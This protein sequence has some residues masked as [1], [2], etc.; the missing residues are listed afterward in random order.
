MPTLVIHAP[1]DKVPEGAKSFEK[2]FKEGLG[3]GYAIA[4]RLVDQVHR[5]CTVVLLD[6]VQKKRAEG[7]LIKL[8]PGEK[9][10]QGIQ[11]YDVY[12]KGQQIVDYKAE[13]LNRFGVA[14]IE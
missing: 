7:R 1:K 11:R 12:F 13:K 3:E 9:T 8:D 2:T 5:G 6:K 10:P 14:L 4:R